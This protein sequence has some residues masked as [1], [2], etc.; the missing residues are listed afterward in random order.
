MGRRPGDLPGRPGVRGEEWGIGMG[1][2]ALDGGGGRG[3][4]PDG[5]RRV[6][7][8]GRGLG[9]PWPSPPC[10]S[11]AGSATSS[12]PTSIGRSAARSLPYHRALVLLSG[13]FKVA[14]GLMLLVPATSR[15]A[16]WGLIALLVAV[17]PA[18]VFM[19]QHAD[20]F[21][22]SRRPSCCSGCRSRPS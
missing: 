3:G 16:A 9:K 11:S 18:N 5:G 12:R 7:K 2:P 6:E 10:S 13:A 20:A 22:R 15:L 17:F 1:K 19:Y 14:L 4:G 21:P 8:M